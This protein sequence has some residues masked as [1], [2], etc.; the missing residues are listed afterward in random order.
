MGRVVE[1]VEYDPAWPESY[2]REARAIRDV[3]AGLKTQTFHIGS[4][5]IPGMLAKP[6]IDILL[7]VESLEGFDVVSHKMQLFGYV[8][9]GEFGI[10]GRRFHFKG[11]DQRTHHI[12]AFEVGSLEINRHLQFRDFLRESREDAEAYALLKIQLGQT[13]RNDPL[14]YN[15]A[16]SIFIRGVDI[17]AREWQIQNQS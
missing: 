8:A 3:L 5:A 17:K 10:P 14:G 13:Y 7:S 6:I 9:L 12:H 4:T 16:K 2:E 1:I 11:G 15:Q